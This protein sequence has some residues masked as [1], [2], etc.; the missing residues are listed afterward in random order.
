M[1]WATRHN[2]GGAQLVVLAPAEGERDRFR[3]NLNVSVEGVPRGAQL[4]EVYRRG[5]EAM[6]EGLTKLD[7]VEAGEVTVGRYPAR[8][9]VYEHVYDRQRLRV[10]AYLI[11]TPGR[12]YTLTGTAS[13]QRFASFLPTF[14]AMAQSFRP[15]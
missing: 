9:L 15:D 6:R 8:R 14:E 2:V 12:C 7:M 4:S 5:F 1:E 13:A 3:E 10:L 11:L